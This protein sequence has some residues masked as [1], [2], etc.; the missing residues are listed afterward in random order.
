MN[1]ISL[2]SDNV[3]VMQLINYTKDSKKPVKISRNGINAIMMNEAEWK[4][5]EETLYLI[6][7]PGMRDSIIEGL[8]IPIEECSDN[9][10]W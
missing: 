10:D 8:S 1:T 4:S 3:D 5:I 7:I 2:S 6:S 9:L